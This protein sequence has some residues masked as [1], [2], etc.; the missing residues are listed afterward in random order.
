MKDLVRYSCLEGTDIKEVFQFE[1]RDRDRPEFDNQYLKL[2]YF[3]AREGIV[4]TLRKVF[5]HKQE[6]VRFFTILRV[7]SRGKSYVNLSVQSQRSPSD[8]VIEN[9]FYPD[10]DFNHDEIR[11]DLEKYLE[12]FNQFAGKLDYSGICAESVQPVSFA[13]RQHPPAGSSE[14][15]L[16]IFGLGGYVKMFIMHHFRKAEKVACVDYKSKITWDFQKRYGFRHGFLVPQSSF[17]LI[18]ST[19]KPA[20]IIATYHSDHALLA[21][22]VYQ[23]NPNSQ[24][25]I[26]KPPTV[27]LEDLDRLIRLYNDGASI[28]IGFNRRFIPFNGYVKRALTG[29]RVIVSC[30]IKE[31]LISPNHWYLWKNQGTR[32]TGNVVHWFDLAQYWIQ[33]TPLELTVMADAEDT[34]SASISVLY[35][36]GSILNITASDQGNSMRGVQEKIEI[37]YGNQTITINDYLWLQH[38]RSNG[39]RIHKRRIRRDKGHSRM[40]SN[41]R[42]ILDGRKESLYPAVDLIH[43]SLLTYYTSKM[44]REGSRTMVIGDIV[45]QY[46]SQLL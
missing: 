13:I 12:Q 32:V 36:N 38:V 9:R 35:R 29:E 40:Y 41:F 44:L 1:N 8:F 20:V 37:R 23:C 27:T 11:L 17:P 3:F 2:L 16:F 18:R 22:Q 6:Q 46:Q 34:E 33:S 10:L 30:S 39:R 45:D 25:F 14:K 7:T 4:S 24:I 21:E 5:A 42:S 15:G 43:T 31:V 28:E 26:E 19:G